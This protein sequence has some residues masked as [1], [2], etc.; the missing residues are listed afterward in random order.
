MFESLMVAYVP[1]SAPTRFNVVYYLM[2]ILIRGL[3]ILLWRLSSSRQSS[4]VENGYSERFSGNR[5]IIQRRL[6]R[7]TIL[8]NEIIKFA[9]INGCNCSSN[10]Y[11]VKLNESRSLNE[12]ISVC[13][14]SI[15]RAS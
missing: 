3:G 1:C 6:L 5:I 13:F 4:T 14:L 15:G 12:A 8:I 7:S 10:R 9:R 2:M 11:L